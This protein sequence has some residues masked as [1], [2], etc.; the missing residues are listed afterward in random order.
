MKPI[1][2]LRFSVRYVWGITDW[3]FRLLVSPY[4]WTGPSVSTNDRV[5]G[6]SVPGVPDGTVTWKDK[7][8]VGEFFTTLGSL[9]REQ[10]ISLVYGCDQ[11][12]FRG[13]VETE[14]V[15]V[16]SSHHD[17][18]DFIGLVGKVFLI[19]GLGVQETYRSILLHII[20]QFYRSSWTRSS[21]I[22]C[23]PFQKIRFLDIQST[24]S[25][26]QDRLG[27]SLIPL[28]IH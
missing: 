4:H 20:V 23:S 5:V 27:I 10:S 22:P 8:G 2:P 19:F 6:S 12:Y 28:L 14:E 24:G 11:I 1:L 18:V 17:R 26:D 13:R 7:G 9:D 15:D 21:W 16:I 25:K 3:L